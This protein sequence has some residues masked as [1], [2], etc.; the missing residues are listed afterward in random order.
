[1]TCPEGGRK[2]RKVIIWFRI[3]EHVRIVVLVWNQTVCFARR[4]GI[5]CQRQLRA[6]AEVTR[7][8]SYGRSQA[9]VSAVRPAER[10]SGLG[11]ASARAVAGGSFAAHAAHHPMS[12]I[13]CFARCAERLWLRRSHSLYLL[14]RSQS[15]RVPIHTVR[16]MTTMTPQC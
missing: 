3:L 8:M 11:T 4:A 5:S 10:Q 15:R 13:R 9:A 16:A 1:M 14:R 12:R 2:E 7:E 6:S